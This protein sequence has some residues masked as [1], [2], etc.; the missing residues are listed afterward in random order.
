MKKRVIPTLTALNFLLVV[1]VA[2]SGDLAE[3]SWITLLVSRLPIFP[4]LLP[5][6][7][8]AAIC[9]LVRQVWMASFHI[10]GFVAAVLVLVPFGTPRVGVPFIGASAAMK[11]VRVM[12]FNVT[13]GLEGA[14]GVIRAILAQK[15]DVFCLQEAS[16]QSPDDPLQ[17]KL[18]ENLPGYE[19]RCE[20]AMVVG[21]RLPIREYRTH[22]LPYASEDRPVQDVTVDWNGFSVRV[23][24]VHMNACEA[25]R[26]L[27]ENFGALHDH[28][29]QVTREQGEQ[30]EEVLK[31][32]PGTPPIVCGDLNQPPRGG[33]YRKLR[34]M[35]HDAFVEAGE[36]FGLTIPARFPMER[37]DYVF[38]AYGWKAQRSWIPSETASDHRPLVADVYPFTPPAEGESAP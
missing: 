29:D 7:V 27:L 23:L 21:S 17:V 1:F 36:G 25:E 3:S 10:A 24:N 5:T 12:T 34:K 33:N 14:D 37:L 31:L 26:L 8:I 32:V 6:L 30:T 28:L 11:T 20:G 13:H 4:F 9:L 22:P 38:L 2:I 18:R 15:P 16:T 35:M 19:L